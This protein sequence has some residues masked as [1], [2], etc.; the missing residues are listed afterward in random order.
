LAEIASTGFGGLKALP[1]TFC[2]NGEGKLTSIHA[3]LGLFKVIV[4]NADGSG[5]RVV[6]SKCCDASGT[7]SSSND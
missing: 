4:I 7:L 6:V 1:T 2:T 3:T 5:N